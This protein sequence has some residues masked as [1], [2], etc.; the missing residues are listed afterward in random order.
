M[1]SVGLP[2][3][4]LSVLDQTLSSL[5]SAPN[6]QSALENAPAGDLVALSQDAVQL[7]EANGLFGSPGTT[8]PLVSALDPGAPNINP[9]NS[10][11][12]VDALLFGFTP[13]S[14]VVPTSP[15]SS[16]A[17]TQAQLLGALFGVGTPAG[18]TNPTIN[19]L[20]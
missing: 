15:V 8:A 6:V 7:Q 20:A 10:L 11:E 1:G 9:S 3:L 17:A 16:A 5:L 14:S 4:G 2:G 19:V 13:T 18:L 12:A